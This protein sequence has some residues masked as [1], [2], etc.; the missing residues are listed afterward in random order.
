MSEKR[1]KRRY[2]ARVLTETVTV[3]LT[4]LQV[5]FLE[6]TARKMEISVGAVCS[7]VVWGWVADRRG[8]RRER[9][10][11]EAAYPTASALADV[12]DL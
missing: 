8:E 11:A 4:A 12:E 9:E 3:H 1:H 2:R 7:E 5:A 6:E 10:Q